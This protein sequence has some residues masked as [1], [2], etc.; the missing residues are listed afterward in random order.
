MREVFSKEWRSSRRDIEK[1]VSIDTRL[2]FS[3]QSVSLFFKSLFSFLLIHTTLHLLAPGEDLCDTAHRLSLFLCPSVFLSLYLSSI[4]VHVRHFHTVRPLL[5]LGTASVGIFVAIY[6]RSLL[7]LIYFY[8]FRDPL[9][10]FDPGFFLKVSFSGEKEERRDLKKEEE[11][12]KVLCVL[13]PFLLSS[14]S[15]Q[16]CLK[17][18]FLGHLLLLLVRLP[19]LVRLCRQRL[20][21]RILRTR[22]LLFFLLIL[23]TL[24][25]LLPLFLHL[26]TDLLL[27][28]PAFLPHTV[29]FLLLPLLVL[30]R[31]RRILTSLL[32]REAFKAIILLIVR[33]RSPLWRSVAILQ[34]G[35]PPIQLQVLPRR[36]RQERD[37]RENLCRQK[38]C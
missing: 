15:F 9:H 25:L 16:A 6:Q 18:V 2:A 37:N 34:G 20:V 19:V 30:S 7:S 33:C 36:C 12:K 3:L 23:L 17:D 29:P 31:T 8:L 27:F 5:M 26:S 32:E 21:F 14:L 4:S 35:A 38:I 11:K 28:H 13:L 22:F 1:E 24:L 10:L